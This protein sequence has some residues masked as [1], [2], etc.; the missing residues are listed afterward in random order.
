MHYVDVDVSGTVTQN[1]E[2]NPRNFIEAKVGFLWGK[3][4]KLPIQPQ[5]V[6]NLVNELNDQAC[7]LDVACVAKFNDLV[8]GQL[9]I[10]KVN[11]FTYLK[12]GGKLGYETDQRF[13]AQNKTISA[14]AYA[15]YEAWN[16]NTFLGSMGIRFSIYL[17]VDEVDP[18]EETPRALA[19]DD[20][21]FRRF[22]GSFSDNV[23]VGNL[24][25]TP[26]TLG[27][28]Y[29]TYQEISPSEIV[30]QAGLDKYHLRTWTLNSVNGISVSYSSGSLP[31]DQQSEDLVAIGWQTYF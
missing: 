1:A 10:D 22:T 11:G 31:F 20:S 23:P 17:T 18:N 9:A 16:K 5:E 24:F 12:L 14:Y 21:Y 6:V 19:G 25:N 4:T 30:K 8:N 7:L 28:N 2:E 15:S 26:M 27:F 13:D 3:Y 29:R